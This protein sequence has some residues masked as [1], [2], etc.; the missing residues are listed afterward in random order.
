MMIG[1]MCTIPA[2]M[3]LARTVIMMMGVMCT[4]P[5][6]MFLARTVIMMMGVMCT[7]PAMMG[8][9]LTAITMFLMV[10]MAFITFCKARNM[11]AAWK[12]MTT[13]LVMMIVFTGTWFMSFMSFMWF[14]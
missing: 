13:V 7:I 8:E 9:Q 2:M 10:M 14:M 1:F 3:F 6:M 5:A 11:D 12:T 4:I